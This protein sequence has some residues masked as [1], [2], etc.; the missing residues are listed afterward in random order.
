MVAFFLSQDFAKR[1]DWQDEK[2]NVLEHLLARILLYL[3][4]YIFVLSYVK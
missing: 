2:L 4:L 1:K 3:E